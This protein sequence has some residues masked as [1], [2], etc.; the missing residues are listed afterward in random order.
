MLFWEEDE[1]DDSSDDAP[2][3]SA[4]GFLSSKAGDALADRLALRGPG[5]SY[6]RSASPTLRLRC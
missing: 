4:V 2:P 6:S 5:R 3:D 1:D